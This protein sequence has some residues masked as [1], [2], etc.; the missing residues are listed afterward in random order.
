MEKIDELVDITKLS[1][2]TV[3][4]IFN[5][6]EECLAIYSNDALMKKARIREIDENT[7]LG[8][9]DLFAFCAEDRMIFIL[10]EPVGDTFEIL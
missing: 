8:D 7:D 4:Y 6:S 10:P 2:N 1:P 3:P 5:M 9:R